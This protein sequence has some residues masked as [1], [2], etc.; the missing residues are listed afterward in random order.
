MS[1]F[2]TSTYWGGVDSGVYVYD[3]NSILFGY[4]ED[5]R[6]Y[7]EEKGAPIEEACPIKMEELESLGCMLLVLMSI[8]V[9]FNF[10]LDWSCL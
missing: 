6:L 5:Y 8:M 3:S 2:S 1:A 4:I 10:I 7:L 9:L